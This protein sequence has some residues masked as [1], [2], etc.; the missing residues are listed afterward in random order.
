M[1]INSVKLVVEHTQALKID[2]T[3]QQWNTLC[4]NVKESA[5][6]FES[7][8]SCRHV[9]RSSNNRMLAIQ[10]I[11]QC[12]IVNILGLSS[13]LRSFHP[14]TIEGRHA[15]AHTRAHTWAFFPQCAGQHSQ[16]PQLLL[17]IMIQRFILQRGK[18]RDYNK[19]HENGQVNVKTSLLRLYHRLQE[20]F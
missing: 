4:I 11:K 16:F 9:I 14:C 8:G 13:S 1:S 12:H 20:V 6:T 7:Q 2:F 5:S 18:E 10:R 3:I 17:L 15:W 19:C